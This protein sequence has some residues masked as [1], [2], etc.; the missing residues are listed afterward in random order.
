M[1][2]K[3]IESTALSSLSL[4]GPQHNVSPNSSNDPDTRSP[5]DL[6]KDGSFF[7]I[8]G[9]VLHLCLDSGLSNCS[10]AEAGFNLGCGSSEFIPYHPGSCIA[11]MS[12]WTL[13]L[14]ISISARFWFCL[15][16]CCI[17]PVMYDCEPPGLV[18]ETSL[19]MFVK[20][21]GYGTRISTFHYIL[22]M[23]A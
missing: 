10:T 9:L 13:F 2:V 17:I 7:F 19:R 4:L 8:C 12:N 15:A 21:I 1:S 5:V 11:L 6:R 14:L 3:N 20:G 22:S 23:Y 16:D 18:F